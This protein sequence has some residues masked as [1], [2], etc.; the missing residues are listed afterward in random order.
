LYLIIVKRIKELFLIPSLRYLE[1]YKEDYFVIENK[2]TNQII[3]CGGINY[4]FDDDVVG[5][6]YC[7][8]M[9]LS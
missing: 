1:K 6:P 9:L 8:P 4:F 3:G 2:F 5:I 7:T